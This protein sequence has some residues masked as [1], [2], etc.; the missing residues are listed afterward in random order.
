MQWLWC[1]S[2]W[3]VRPASSLFRGGPFCVVSGTLPYCS[4]VEVVTCP[5]L[6]VL[7]LF[8]FLQRHAVWGAAIKPFYRDSLSGLRSATYDLF[9]AVIKLYRRRRGARDPDL[10]QP[11][12]PPKV[13]AVTPYEHQM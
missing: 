2:V 3:Q 4:A 10:Q 5:D 13:Q 8:L 12:R 9:H 1:L 6:A 11:L 7:F